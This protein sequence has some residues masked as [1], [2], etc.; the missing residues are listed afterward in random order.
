MIT[1]LLIH[2][3]N[4]QTV[5]ILTSGTK[6]SLR[7]LSVVTNKIIWASGSNGKVTKSN[8]GG[9]TWQWFTVKGFEKSDFRD[10]E[11]FNDSTAIIIAIDAPAYILKT[12][13]SGL[14]WTIVY[15]NETKGMFLDAMDFVDDKHG[16]VVGDPIDGYFF[17]A[18]TNDGGET[19]KEVSIN[20]RPVAD[21]GEACF[22]SSGTNIQMINKS[23]FALVSG[24]LSAH[25]FLNNKKLNLP[26]LQGKES[27]GANSIAVKTKRKIIVVG[28]DFNHKDSTYKNCYITKNAGKSWHSPKISPSGY[29]SCVLHITK[30]NWITCGLNGVDFT[31]DNG[32]TF[33][34]ISGENFHVCALSKHRKEVF[35]AGNSGKIG[36]FSK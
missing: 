23:H 20:E 3:V 1:A 17:I 6:T 5:K 33:T 15:K 34:R 4:G 12:T 30:N 7:G 28:G 22:A 11:A 27:T 14:T 16:V 13:N 35:L 19:W 31:H 2:H 9:K 21:S 24:G 29:R 10:I 8:D 36:F 25:L 32:R 26:I 18:R